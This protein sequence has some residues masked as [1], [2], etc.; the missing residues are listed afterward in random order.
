M[1]GK[2]CVY[3][4]GYILMKKLNIIT[5]TIAKGVKE[6]WLFF[7]EFS[8]S[9]VRTKCKEIVGYNSVQLFYLI[10]QNLVKNVLY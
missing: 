1:V 6:K 5:I 7:N 3:L 4:F 2:L 10:K 9:V 8:K